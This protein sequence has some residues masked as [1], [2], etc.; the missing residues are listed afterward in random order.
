MSVHKGGR[1]SGCDGT[2]D[3]LVDSFNRWLIARAKVVDGCPEAVGDDGKGCLDLYHQ[4]TYG[5]SDHAYG[6][7]LLSIMGSV[8]SLMD[9]NK[10]MEFALFLEDR[11]VMRD[12]A[13]AKE[14]RELMALIGERPV[15]AMTAA[16][17][18]VIGEQPA[19]TTLTAIP[20]EDERWS[21][22]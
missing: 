5:I 21:A 22:T 3:E 12:A 4:H 20:T 19:T 13:A 1:G 10:V 17:L 2:C 16:E 11:K 9:V 8:Q 18:A 14:C 15:V 6:S 7:M